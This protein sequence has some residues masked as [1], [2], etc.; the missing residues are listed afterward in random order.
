M[1][2]PRNADP[3]NAGDKSGVHDPTRTVKRVAAISEQLMAD[4]SPAEL[5]AERARLIEQ[6]AAGRAAPRYRPVLSCPA[7]HHT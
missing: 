3:R 5:S 6:P 4:N 7:F 1:G 2:E